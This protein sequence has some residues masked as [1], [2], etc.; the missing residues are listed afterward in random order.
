VR[1]EVPGGQGIIEVLRLNFK[2]QVMATD[3]LAALEF[4]ERYVDLCS[5]KKLERFFYPL[6]AYKFGEAFKIE[7]R[8]SKE[9]AVRASGITENSMF[10][11]GQKG[12]LTPADTRK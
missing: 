2:L 11:E 3:G 10:K 8:P 7:P 6:T 4:I 12:I 5:M 1:L 9:G